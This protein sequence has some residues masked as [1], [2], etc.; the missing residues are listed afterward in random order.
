MRNLA[1]RAAQYLWTHKKQLAGAVVIGLA[2]GKSGGGWI[3]GL[4]AA[5]KA[6]AG[7]P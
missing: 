3:D 2:A 7:S 1:R 6:Y 4:V 5:A